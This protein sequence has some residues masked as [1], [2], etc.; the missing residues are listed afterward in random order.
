MHLRAQ[1]FLQP[2]PAILRAEHN[3]Y[4]QK[5]ERLGHG[6]EYS[7]GLQ[8]AI[9]WDKFTW[10]V[11]PGYYIAGLQPA[12]TF[13]WEISHRVPQALTTAAEIH[14]EGPTCALDQPWRKAA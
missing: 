14:Y 2:R 12:P 10:G 6:S 1:G 4:Q 5:R 9:S 11:A 3:V 7:A 8:P 13:E